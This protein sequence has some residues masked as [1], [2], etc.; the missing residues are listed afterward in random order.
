MTSLTYGIQKRKKTATKFTDT[1]N[2]NRLVVARGHSLRGGWEKWVKGVK[3]Y[4]I[5]NHVCNVQH[6]VT[7]NNIILPT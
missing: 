3:R 4:K 6:G 2:R 1:Q 5:I 7:V